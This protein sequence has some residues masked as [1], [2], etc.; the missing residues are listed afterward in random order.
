MES[1]DG[2]GMETSERR[3]S[4]GVNQR[5]LSCVLCQ[6]RKKKCDRTFP[7]AN[8]M[9]AKATCVPP[10]A[11]PPRPRKR[12]FAE[13]ELLAKL[14]H[15]ENLL[16]RVGVRL[17]DADALKVDGIDRAE[18]RPR[19]N[20]GATELTAR[21][22][23][24]IDALSG[25]TSSSPTIVKGKSK[26]SERKAAESIIETKLKTSGLSEEFQA[27]ERLLEGSSEDEVDDE[28]IQATYTSMFSSQDG[29]LFGAEPMQTDLFASHP[30]PIHIFKLWQTY[31]DNIHP[32]TM[33]LH[34]PTTQQQ[35]MQAIG[36]LRNVSRAT[37]ALLFSIYALALTSLTHEECEAR[38]G[39]D[40]L[41]LVA[42][43]QLAAQQALRNADFL[44]TADMGVLQ[45]LLLYL[46][47][48]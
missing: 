1:G 28:P 3:A 27:T 39:E 6:Q 20:G 48:L 31:L 46:V 24:Q 25:S 41:V 30:Q 40:K 32:L 34:A 16:K 2:M 18:E 37:E 10:S 26:D 42:K 17:D 29:V 4:S 38:F 35:I 23:N 7:C 33:I 21:D 47:S 43:Y 13:A 12:R 11:L 14:R 5:M 44:R 22:P 9:K 8:C 15:Y 36:D 45:A 19:S